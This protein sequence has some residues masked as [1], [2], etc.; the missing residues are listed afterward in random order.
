MKKFIKYTLSLGLV[1]LM[2]LACSQDDSTAFV[3]DISAPSN[4]SA[5]VSITQDN[6]GMVTITP[7]AQGA[8]SY[9]VDFGDGSEIAKNITPGN[10]VEHAYQEGTYN[11]TITAVGLNGKTTTTTQEVVVSFKAPENLVVTIENDPAISKQVNVSATADYA[12]VFEVYFNEPGNEDPVI[13]N[14]DETISYQ[15]QNAGVY[16]I[17][18][19]AMSAAIETTEYSVEFE[20]TAILQP[21]NAAPVPFRAQADVISVYSD[22][23][24]NPNPI[25][26]Y[27]NWGQST[28]YT[29]IEVD[30]N[31]IIQYGDINYQG[32]DFSTVPIDAST[33]EFLHV[34]IWTANANFNAKISPISSGPNETAYDLELV[35]NQWTSF[36]IPISFFTDA[37]PSLDFSDIIQ[38][39]FEGVPSGGGTIFIDN[40][41]FYKESQGNTNAITPIDFEAD[42]ALSSFDGGAIS[43][44]ANPDTNGNSS[45]MVTQMVKNSGQPWGGSKI[46]V[47][48]PFNF[49]NP[50][51]T[52]KVWSPRAGLNLLMKFED[53]VPWPNVTSTAEVTATTTTA[54]AWETLTFDF[55]GID[56]TINWYNMVLIMDN[57]TQGD[58]S[59]NYTIYLDDVTS[60]PMLD[61]EPKFELSSFDG[62]AISVIAN[63][64]TNGNSSSM[65]AQMVKNSGQ[66]WAGSKIT[67][68]TPFNFNSGTTVKVKVWSPRAGLNLLMKFEDDVPWPNV[69]STAEVTATTTTANAWETLTFDF[70]GL[71]MNVNW[72]N[73]VMIMDNGTQGDGSAN[74]T[75]YI[76]DID[77]N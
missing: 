73:L 55:T 36:N 49:S 7:L 16:T 25:D 65:V 68:P 70:S 53:D 64:D 43:V 60:S 77:V 39:K 67:F 66:P 72:Y 47:D 35:Q 58:G 29:Q 8:V 42:Y 4:V 44:V 46:T 23:Y 37:N 26:Y 38:F 52:A 31:N 33:M 51:I 24:T 32:I 12:T 34:D 71:D 28:T 11:A 76:D 69:T 63:P 2:A 59:A 9:M 27:P 10:G 15:Y 22:S 6:T 19:V 50:V 75:I 56:T 45:S 14:L 21:L 3:D 61:F 41:Y 40:L 18:V 30:G 13:L 54:N 48:M 62:G 1:V 5:A 17:K 20:V 74:Y 57:G